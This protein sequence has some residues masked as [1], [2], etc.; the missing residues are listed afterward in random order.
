MTFSYFFPQRLLKAERNFYDQKFDNDEK[1][2]LI[3]SSHVGQLNA[4]FIEENIITKTRFRVFN[5]AYQGD[6]PEKRLKTV[7]EIIRLKPKIVVY[8]ISYRD[9]NVQEEN[10]FFD[11]KEKFHDLIAEINFNPENPKLMT[12]EKIRSL[13][14]DSTLNEKEITFTNT[15]FFSY[16][17]DTQIPIL[18]QT[19][20][21][22]QASIS[23]ATKINLKTPTTNRQVLMLIKLV[24]ELKMHN[25]KVILFATPL[26]EVYLKGLSETQKSTFNEI[27]KEIKDQTDVEVY[28]LT[29]KYSTMPIWTNISHVAF[30]V[31]SLIYSKD[32][33]KIIEKE[34]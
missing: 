16:N 5:L 2:L 17:V 32:I 31:N 29:E 22:N 34:I 27:L 1:I 3:G 33:S 8:G 13:Q 4:T 26:H 25:I 23:E 24:N 6:T 14:S 20:L 12:L 9:F 7:D 28:D 11:P 19:M 15:P 30:N 18:N 21:E 10:P